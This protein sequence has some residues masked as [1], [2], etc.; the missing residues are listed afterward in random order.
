MRRINAAAL[1][2]VKTSLVPREKEVE[3]DS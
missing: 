2:D 1:F 3:T